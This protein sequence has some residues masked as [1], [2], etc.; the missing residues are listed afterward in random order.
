LLRGQRP[1]WEHGPMK[2]Q[3]LTTQQAA[4]ISRVVEIIK[5]HAALEAFQRR[6]NDTFITIH[7][8]IVNAYRDV[9]KAMQ[10]FMDEAG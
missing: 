10:P 9:V 6:N 1:S 3:Q 8:S 7:D 2:T 5:D 4:A